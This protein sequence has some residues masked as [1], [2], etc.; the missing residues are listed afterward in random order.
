VETAADPELMLLGAFSRGAPPSPLAT[1]LIERGSV[2]ALLSHCSGRT[3]PRAGALDLFPQAAR[4]VLRSTG[5]G[6]V[7]FQRNGPLIQ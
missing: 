7:Q 4:S 3:L 1:V 6:A 2:N 5:A